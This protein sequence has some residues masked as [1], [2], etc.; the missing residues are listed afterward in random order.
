MQSEIHFNARV[1][2]FKITPELNLYPVLKHEQN[3]EGKKSNG[4]GIFEKRY[5]FYT[6]IFFSFIL[7]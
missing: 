7:C 6:R 4:D 2:E 1:M 3:E 5:I